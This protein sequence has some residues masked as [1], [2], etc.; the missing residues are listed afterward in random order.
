[1]PGFSGHRHMIKVTFT[2]CYK[3][4]EIKIPQNS[5]SCLDSIKKF[6]E[7][8]QKQSAV[9]QYQLPGYKIEGF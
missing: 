5:F 8:K 9:I 4:Q 7:S 6:P 1:M 3:H 2:S